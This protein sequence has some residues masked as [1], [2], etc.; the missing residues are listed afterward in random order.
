MPTSPEKIESL[1]G[2]ALRA[3]KV[4]F[5]YDT[6]SGLSRSRLHL[7]L[8]ADDLQENTQKK[9]L[10]LTADRKIP[11]IRCVRPLEEA[12]HKPGVKVV[13]ITNKQMAKAMTRFANENFI[14]IPEV[15]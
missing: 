10:R 12:L 1:L 15:D 3:G 11:A 7:V 8:F 13:G 14:L 6:L 2:F 4:A 5:G 9:L